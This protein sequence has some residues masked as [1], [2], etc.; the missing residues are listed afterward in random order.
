M[1]LHPTYRVEV[2]ANAALVNMAYN[3]KQDGKPSTKNA[4]KF[5][6]MYNASF[7][8]GGCNEHIKSMDGN[9]AHISG[10][11]IIHQDSQKVVAEYKEAAFSIN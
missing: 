3:V 1:T 7:A 6:E 9:T 5:A 4:A 8:P 11:F 10:V 2:I